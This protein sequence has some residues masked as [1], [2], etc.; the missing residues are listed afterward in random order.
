MSPS[1]RD[2]EPERAGPGEETPARKP[3]VSAPRPGTVP[4]DLTAELLRRVQSGDDNARE[5]LIERYIPLLQRWASG[6]LPG[7]ARSIAET[8]DLVQ[9]TLIRALRRVEAFEP[10]RE[11][12]FLSYLRKILLNTIREEIRRTSKHLHETLPDEAAGEGPDEAEGRTLELYEDGLDR[13]NERQREAAILRLE[14]GY[15]YP[16]IAEAIECPS[17]DAARMIVNRALIQLA[18]AMSET[19]GP[20]PIR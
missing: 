5:R 11:G 8:D 1:N 16:Q 4:L 14:F 19:G 17:P 2:K 6:R 15:S 10:R 20:P 12:A 18:S 9:V 7:T 13:L 3:R